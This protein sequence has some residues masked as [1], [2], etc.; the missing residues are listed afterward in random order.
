M[1]IL[2]VVA[3][4]GCSAPFDRGAKWRGLVIR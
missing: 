2:G 1:L 4:R 3:K